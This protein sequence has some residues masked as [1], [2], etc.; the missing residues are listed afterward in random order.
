MSRN[1]FPVVS[2]LLIVIL[3]TPTAFAS[4]I[5]IPAVTKTEEG[6]TTLLE[7]T[8]LPGE[9]NI[10]SGIQPLTSIN[11]QRSQRNA[12]DAAASFL[13]ADLTQF[14]VI[15]NIK[16]NATQV[17]GPSAG[18]A[19]ALAVVAEFQKK[20][21]PRTISVTGSVDSDGNIG[22]VGG[23]FEKANA[24]Q[25]MGVTLFI[26]PEGE[27]T[28][29]AVIEQRNEITPGQYSIT[30]ISTRVDLRDYAPETWGMHVVEA[31][32]LVTLYDYIFNGIDLNAIQRQEKPV[33]LPEFDPAIAK[34]PYKLDVY[35]SFV[36]DFIE[37]SNASISDANAALNVNTSI[38]KKSTLNII[39][40]SLS[41]AQAQNDDAS[42]L[43]AKNY[44]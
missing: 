36:S 20:E 7:V 32:D 28:Q 35:K 14:D 31:G 23:I 11:T 26:I 40:S 37:V 16:S 21:I 25:S 5:I 10:F 13:E 8:L 22:P 33:E 9:G 1:F 44:L 41:I 42:E 18:A 17:D 3:L 34:I 6:L 19:M 43:L 30:P 12:V 39:A 2:L 27:A 29:T 38:D 24:A 4:E 15:F